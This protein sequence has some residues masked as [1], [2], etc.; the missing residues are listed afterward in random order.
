M[1]SYELL[2]IHQKPD[3]TDSVPEE[4]IDTVPECKPEV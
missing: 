1:E 3:K 2:T 4:I